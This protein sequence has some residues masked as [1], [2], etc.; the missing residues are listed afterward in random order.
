MPGNACTD[1][2]AIE[3][4]YPACGWIAFTLLG[5]CI[6]DD[7]TTPSPSHVVHP[8]RKILRRRRPNNQRNWSPV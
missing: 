7:R 8:Q 4:F 3:Q 1:L 2:L 5:S 6:L